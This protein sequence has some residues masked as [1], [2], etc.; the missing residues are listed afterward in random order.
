MQILHGARSSR[1]FGPG[2]GAA[3]YNRLLLRIV[4]RM[5]FK[6]LAWPFVAGVGMFA[7]LTIATVV[8]QEAARFAIRY[9]VPA[10][11]FLQLFGL[12]TP[13]FI[14][15]SIPMGVLLGTLISVGRLS[16]DNEITALRTCGVS[17]YRLLAPYLIVGAFLSGITLLGSEEIVPQCNSRLSE[18]RSD[19]RSG[20]TGGAKQQRVAIPI[21]E[22]GQTRWV[23]V[24]DS[25]EG[26]ELKGVKLL[27]FD[28]KSNDRD[29]Y[30]TAE[31]ADWEGDNWT[32]YNLRQVQLKASDEAVVLRA[33]KA[34][35][36]GFSITP[37]SIGLRTKSPDDLNILQLR[38]LIAD[39]L[40]A[41]SQV[42]DTEIRDFRTRLYFKYSIPLTPLFFIIIAVPLAI[43]PQRSSSTMGMGM[44]LLI[45]LMY[46]ALYT[47][48]QK[49]GATG[50]LLPLLAGWIPNTALLVTGMALIYRRERS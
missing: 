46:Y 16:S 39:L 32:F 22:A 30:I 1:Q 33:E 10:P 45:V 47:M 20:K 11:L 13:Q 37:Q 26:T 2:V 4:D 5:I 24:A 15:L 49:L 44:A 6:E 21:S 38:N 27:Y 19:I 25:M 9:N 35:V 8:L 29:F 40:K 42:A 17:L 50:V 3:V 18:L 36:P 14:L 34:R 28:A 7:L 48:C 23:L 12:A 41:G 31:R 43:R